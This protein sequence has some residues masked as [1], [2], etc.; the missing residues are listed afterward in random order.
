MVFS[1]LSSQAESNFGAGFVLGDP[2][3]F[4]FKY[5]LSKRNSIDAALSWS[6]SINVHMHADYLWNKP[7][8]FFLDH[9]PMDLFYGIGG[10]IRDPDNKKYRSDDDS[11]VHLG[12]RAPV[13]LRFMFNDPSVELFSELALIFNVTPSTSADLDFGIGARYFF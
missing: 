1:T 13:G 10:R 8:L 2:T 5:N 3:G 11:D 6:G 7:K 9:Y 4:S 12:V